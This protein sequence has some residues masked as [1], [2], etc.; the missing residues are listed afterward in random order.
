MAADNRFSGLK[1]VD[2]ASFIADPAPA[3]ILSGGE[4]PRVY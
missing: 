4:F 1:V 3:M 2:L